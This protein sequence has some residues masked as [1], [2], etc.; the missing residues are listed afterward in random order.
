MDNT[1]E[2]IKC[3]DHHNSCEYQVCDCDNILATCIRDALANGAQCPQ[4]VQ[5]KDL[6]TNTAN[7]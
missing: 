4:T 6:M 7:K 3:L 1:L 5:L 2:N